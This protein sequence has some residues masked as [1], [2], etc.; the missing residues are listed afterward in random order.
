MTWPWHTCFKP[1]RYALLVGFVFACGVQAATVT[2]QV[3]L[4]NSDH[5]AVKAK[6]DYS[7]VVVWLE[8]LVAG[9]PRPSAY[10]PKAAV[11]DQRNKAFTPHVLAIEVGTAVDFPNSDPIQHNAFSNGDSQV[12][13][14]HLY[15]PQTTR[16]VVFRRPGIAKVFCNVHETMSA[17]IAVLPTP[18]FA[19]TGPDGGFQIQAPA[20]S[21][22]LRFWHER[23]RADVLAKLEQQISVAGSN[24]TLG[25]VQ[26][27]EEG[28][29]PE[30][31]K[32]KWG[33][34]YSAAREEYVFYPGGRR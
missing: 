6:R 19:V 21:Y 34:E 24:L 17:I 18:Y 28:Y 30:P 12:F 20:G 7:G 14:L 22:R 4:V 27:S 3:A 23:S 10:E 31:H 5:P 15:A 8:P 1:V 13:D 16:R 25:R 29:S 9:S 33:L 26:I 11:V 2:G 32:N